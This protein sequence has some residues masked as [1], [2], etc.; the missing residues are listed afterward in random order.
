MAA[1]GKGGGL[2][3]VLALWAQASAAEEP[4]WTQLVFGPIA[5]KTRPVP[6]SSLKELSAEG[7]VDAPLNNVKDVL[8]DVSN[9]PRYMPYV[10]EARE[11]GAEADGSRY[12]YTRLALPVV[13]GRDCVL[14]LF[15]DRDGQ[16][17][18]QQVFEDHWVAA[19]D[20]LP[21]RPNIIRMK[22]NQGS[23]QITAGPDGKTHVVYRLV[24]DPGGWLPAFATEAGSRSAI[25]DTFRAV[26]AEAKRR[27]AGH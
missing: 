16:V 9:L 18:A 15:I 1:L 21:A 6:Q 7:D 20:R 14:H 27:F 4:P 17:G 13:Q 23:W 3:A 8:L 10:K 5:V 25:L 22:T 26:E 19:P 12:V 2:F 24:V 11:L